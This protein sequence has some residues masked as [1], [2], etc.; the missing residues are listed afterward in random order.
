MNCIS[1]IIDKN[2]ISVFL[3][4][5]S[6]TYVLTINDNVQSYNGTWSD[7]KKHFNKVLK[8]FE[9]NAAKRLEY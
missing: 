5:N 7:A 1:T 8:D 4:D 2:Y 6:N 3:N 9:I